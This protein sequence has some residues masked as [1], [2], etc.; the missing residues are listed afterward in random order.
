MSILLEFHGDKLFNNF[1][2]FNGKLE[3]NNQKLKSKIQS[4]GDLVPPMVE[5][6][7]CFT[8]GTRIQIC[9]PIGPDYVQREFYHGKDKIHCCASWRSNVYFLHTEPLLEF[10]LDLAV[11]ESLHCGQN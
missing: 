2:F 6:V 8:D 5:S 1:T 7:A 9:K 11:L 3:I 4:G 10:V